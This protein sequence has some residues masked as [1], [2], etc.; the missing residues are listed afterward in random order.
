MIFLL[1]FAFNLLNFLFTPYYEKQDF[2]LHEVPIGIVVTSLL[3]GIWFRQFWARYLLAAIMLLR[4]V[5]SCIFLPKLADRMLSNW[6]F[7]VGLLS[8]PALYAAI[9]WALLALPSIHR[10]V[11]RRAEWSHD[12]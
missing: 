11:S 6:I 12:L 7:A 9:A 5:A 3:A 4:V 8:G 2:L 1:L 10:L